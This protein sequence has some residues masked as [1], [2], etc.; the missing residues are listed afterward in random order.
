MGSFDVV[1]AFETLEHLLPETIPAA[2]AELARISRR[3][4]VVTIPSFGPRPPLPSGWFAGKVRSERLAHYESLGPEFEGPVPA[5][6]LAVDAN[7]LPLEGHVCIASFQWWRRQ[8]ERVGL[9]A[10]LET[11]AAAY[12]LLERAGVGGFFDWMSFRHHGSIPSH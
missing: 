8:F 12:G 10:A 7:G 2:L 1:T 5:E 9:T 3:W 4:V 11:D 6:D